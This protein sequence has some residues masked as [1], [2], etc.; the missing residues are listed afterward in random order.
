[1]TERPLSWVHATL[2]GFEATSEPLDAR[3]TV[4]TR[5]R[6]AKRSDLFKFLFPG[7]APSTSNPVIDPT[8]QGI[9]FTQVAVAFMVLVSVSILRV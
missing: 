5:A 9:K 3:I 1:M 6:I 2:L 4:Q 8:S 7:K